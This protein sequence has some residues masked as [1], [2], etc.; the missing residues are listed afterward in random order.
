MKEN[1]EVLFPSGFYPDGTKIDWSLYTNP[2]QF[3]SSEREF[4]IGCL[5]GKFNPELSM[6]LPTLQD[7]FRIKETSS[8]LKTKLAKLNFIKTCAQ[9]L[10]ELPYTSTQ[11]NSIRKILKE[12]RLKAP[13]ITILLGF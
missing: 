3:F 8:K 5:I 1:L 10:Q 7:I 13:A 6:M 11:L 4:I 12:T 9:Q 2:A